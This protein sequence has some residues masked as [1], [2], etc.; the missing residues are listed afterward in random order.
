MSIFSQRLESVMKEK[1]LRQHQLCRMTGISKSFISSYLAGRFSPKA[2]KLA[3]ISKALGVSEGW[4]MGYES[5]AKYSYD[6]GN[7]AK[8]P[9]KDHSG[10]VV[11]HRPVVY[12]G[13]DSSKLTFYICTDRDNFPHI[14][15]GDL[16]LVHKCADFQQEGYTYAIRK[17]GK[18]TFRTHRF[19]GSVLVLSAE[20]TAPTIYLDDYHSDIIVMGKVLEIR[21]EMD[22]EENKD[23]Q[24][25]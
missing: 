22:K 23:E 8:I 18:I 5:S 1:N 21:R 19:N 15:Q 24:R 4:L 2:D 25:N 16:V 7:I 17:D 10:K 11:A 12:A 14:K 9:V 6:P 13:G 3:A 20:N